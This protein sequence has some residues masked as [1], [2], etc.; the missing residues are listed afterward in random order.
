MGGPT[1]DELHDDHRS[2]GDG[3]GYSIDLVTQ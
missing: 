2:Q 1:I 3:I